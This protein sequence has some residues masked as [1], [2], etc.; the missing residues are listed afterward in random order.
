M[1]GYF[2]ELHGST[3]SSARSSSVE[4][5]SGKAQF[6]RYFLTI[7]KATVAHPEILLVCDSRLQQPQRNVS[8]SCFRSRPSACKVKS[9]K[10]SW[11]G[12][13]H[14]H[15]TLL[16]LAKRITSTWLRCFRTFGG[17]MALSSHAIPLCLAQWQKAVKSRMLFFQKHVSIKSSDL[18][19]PK[20]TKRIFQNHIKSFKV[21]FYQGSV[22][23]KLK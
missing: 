17:R 7:S 16:F 22:R 8:Y 14:Q 12:I 11:W 3:W 1:K 18:Q 4:K 6:T 15:C 2:H 9:Q 19:A 23:V 20:L 13:F 5:L 21:K 10:Y